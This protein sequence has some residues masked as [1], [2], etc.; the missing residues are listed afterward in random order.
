MFAIDQP[1]TIEADFAQG[2]LIGQGQEPQQCGFACAI[3]ADQAVDIALADFE[4]DIIEGEMPIELF[5]QILG[6]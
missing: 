3:R 1:L 4:T 5:A 6:G 2:R